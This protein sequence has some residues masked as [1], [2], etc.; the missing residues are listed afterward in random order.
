M[1]VAEPR[2]NVCIQPVKPGAD[3]SP[4]LGLALHA[5][6]GTVWGGLR[7]WREGMGEQEGRG[8]AAGGTGMGGEEAADREGEWSGG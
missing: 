2:S 1:S 4:P 6:A 5:V 8:K 3:R 7:L